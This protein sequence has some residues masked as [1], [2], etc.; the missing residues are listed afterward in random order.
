MIHAPSRVRE[1]PAR[2]CAALFAAGLLVTTG[3]TTRAGECDPLDWQEDF[4]IVPGDLSTT[5]RNAFFV[6]EPGFQTVLA[7]GSEQVTITVLNETET[8]AGIVTRVVEEREEEDG[9]LAE[10]SRN[11][12]AISKTSGDV[13]YFGEAVDTHEDGEIAGH[14]G[15]WRAGE[16]GC[17]PGLIMPG[18]PAVGQRYY[19]EV[20]PEKAMDRAEVVSLTESL[21][22][23]AGIFTGCLRTLESTPLDQDEQEYKTY[24]PGIGLIQDE[25]L[26]LVRYGFIAEE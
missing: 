2:G 19:Q 23:P 12:F 16:G 22:T 14:P 17:R 7:A 3:P 21:E 9:E 18:L 26:L 15:T 4:P 5:G 25:D 1:C 20:A 24:A 11:Y 10:V 8:V 6:L 13:Y